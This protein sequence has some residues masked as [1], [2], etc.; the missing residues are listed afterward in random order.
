MKNLFLLSILSFSLLGLTN[1]SDD[2]DNEQAVSNEEKV[3]AVLKSIETGDS[4]PIAYINS[5]QYTQHNQTIADGLAGFGAALAELPEGSARVKTVRVFQ[6][7][8]Y[9]FAHTDYNFFGPKIGFDI[10]RFENGLI[11]EHWDNLQE[12]ATELNPSGHSMIDGT[13]Y[14]TDIDKTEANK[15]LVKNFVSDILV[16]GNMD[17][18]GNYF[19]GDNYI[20]HN[21][22]IGDGLS[23]LGEALDDM[24]ANGIEM[25]YTTIHKVLGQGNFVL[26]VSE[27]TFAGNHTA[28]YDLF[29]V[30][31]DKIAEHWDV[32]ETITDPSEAQNSNGK[33][34]F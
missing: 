10:F 22:S 2:D 32:I 6:D 16:D 27:G 1:C 8:D 31:N 29:R 17:V 12:T 28:Y 19:D 7:G 5:D 14:I 26:V 9:V 25:I 33:F 34:N 24:A 3:V 20:Q 4:E 11:V 30:E 21:P 18:L 15:T 13:T 23:G